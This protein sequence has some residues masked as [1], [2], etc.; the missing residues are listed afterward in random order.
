MSKALAVHHGAFGRA[1]VYH[2]D[3]N[4][5]T[6]AHR[7]GHLCFHLSG[8]AAHITV[9]DARQPV[10]RG[11]AVAINPWQAHD[12]ECG[13]EAGLYLVLYI[14]PSWFLEYGH[15]GLS[16]FRFGRDQIELNGRIR[17]AIDRVGSLLL[18]GAGHDVLS[19]HLYELTRECFDQS[20]QWAPGS[21]PCQDDCRAF[22]DYRVRR[23]IDLI[24]SHLGDELDIDTVAKEAG[25]SRPH[26]FKLFRKQ[27]GLTP[28]LYAN[29]LRMEAAIS[30]LTK[31][32]KSIT[33]ISFDL[34]FSSQASFSR[35]FALNAGISPSNYRHVAAMAGR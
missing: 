7:E 10:S 32:N 31:T 11:G 2:L 8:A 21:A 27:T 23:S 25:L 16:G 19:G 18:N 13:E 24:R 4:I 35:F 14:S 20:W 9:D 30:D 6:H 5:R 17:G 22:S 1:T 26:F 33:D 3:R 15:S 29:T 28:N 12:F 34:C